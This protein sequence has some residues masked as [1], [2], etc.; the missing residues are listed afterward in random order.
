MI[1]FQS[2]LLMNKF[3]MIVTTLTKEFSTLYIYIYS[4]LKVIK[5]KAAVQ[6]KDISQPLIYPTMKPPILMHI[7]IMN[8]GTFS[9][10]APEISL[11]YVDT[12]VAN[13]SGLFSSNQP[14]SYYN[15]A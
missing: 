15:I 1:T 11:H 10:I 7:V 3:L 9:P 4:L 13:S 2:L 6:T 8:E 12:L 5:G 14:I